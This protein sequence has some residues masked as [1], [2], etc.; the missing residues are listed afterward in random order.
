[1]NLTAAASSIQPIA[2]FTVES[3]AP[4]FGSFARSDGNNA[5]T[6]NGRARASANV[7]MPRIGRTHCEPVCADAAA[8][9]TVPMNGAVQVNAAITNVSP[10][11]STPHVVALFAAFGLLLFVSFCRNAG[12]LISITSRSES[13]N[14]MN[15]TPKP[16][17]TYGFDANW[18][19]PAAPTV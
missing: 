19:A 15:N 2:P 12:G 10:M 18:F 8:T 16:R 9:R 3:H 7:V 5:R 4:D 17:L 13:A 14:T 1:M 6:K 11:P